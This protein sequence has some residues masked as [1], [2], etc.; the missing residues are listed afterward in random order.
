VAEGVWGCVVLCVAEGGM[1]QRRMVWESKGG[2]CVGGRD[3]LFLCFWPISCVFGF[4]LRKYLLWAGLL[5]RVL[6]RLMMGWGGVRSDSVSN[7]VKIGEEMTENG[8]KHVFPLCAF[9]LGSFFSLVSRGSNPGI[10]ISFS[11]SRTSLVHSDCIST[12]SL[13]I[14]QSFELGQ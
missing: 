11:A 12:W 9:F 10:S 1:C 8:R 7:G 3:M 14:S 13:T 6:V 5:S 2:G 4:L